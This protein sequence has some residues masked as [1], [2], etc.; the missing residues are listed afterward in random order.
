[1]AAPIIL[2]SKR[3]TL[4]LYVIG[5]GYVEVRAPLHIL[6]LEIQK[7]IEKHQDWI[8]K[9]QKEMANRP[10]EHK[11][12]SDGSL[13]YF[14]GK[15][16]PLTIK[17][18]SH[19]PLSFDGFSFTLSKTHQAKTKDLFIAWYKKQAGNLIKAKTESLAKQHNFKFKSIK[20]G[21]AKS[22]WGSCSGI[23]KLSFSLRLI[24]APIPVIDYVIVHELVHTVHHNHS[25]NFWSEVSKYCPNYKEEK[26]WLKQNGHNLT[27]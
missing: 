11:S 5:P 19:P 12:F 21:N 14:L 7:F 2:R 26:K 23:N 6:D 24:M 10:S 27:L 4:S 20:I 9:R 13:F 8:N 17:P 16:Y 15:T 1:M 18:L 22:R 3:K 25:K